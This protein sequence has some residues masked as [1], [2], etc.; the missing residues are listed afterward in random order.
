[1]G[2]GNDA[3]RKATPADAA[4]SSTTGTQR[5]NQLLIKRMLGQSL[6]I[7]GGPSKICSFYSKEGLL[8]IRKNN[9]TSKTLLRKHK[10]DNNR[11]GV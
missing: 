7:G 8:T 11:K 10:Q 9:R 1:M 3:A 6:S 5:Q 4:P 2:P